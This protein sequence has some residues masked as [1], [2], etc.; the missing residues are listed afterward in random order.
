MVAGMVDAIISP[1]IGFTS[2]QRHKAWLGLLRRVRTS[3]LGDERH[4]IPGV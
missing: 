4:G 1:F 2:L 3:E